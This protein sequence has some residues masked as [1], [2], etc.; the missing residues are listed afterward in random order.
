[1]RTEALNGLKKGDIVEHIKCQRSQWKHLNHGSVDGVSVSGK[2]VY[3]QWYDE[4]RKQ[5][6]W[7]K[8]DARLIVKRGLR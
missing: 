4:N 8:Y 7:A 1:M 5:F 6:H 2:S 3:V